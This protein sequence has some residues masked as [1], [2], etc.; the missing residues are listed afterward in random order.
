ML[1]TVL[2]FTVWAILHAFFMFS[3][4]HIT[5]TGHMSGCCDRHGA[6]IVG[7]C[8]LRML[9]S[10]RSL[11]EFSHSAIVILWAIYILGLQQND[12]ESHTLLYVIS[13]GYHIYDSYWNIRDVFVAESKNSRHVHPHDIPDPGKGKSSAL[14]LLQNLISAGLV[15]LGLRAVSNELT[16]WRSSVVPLLM[17]LHPSSSWNTPSYTQRKALAHHLLA[18]TS[19]ISSLISLNLLIHEL[20]NIFRS[21]LKLY[22]ISTYNNERMKESMWIHQDSGRNNTAVAASLGATAWRREHKTAQADRSAIEGFLSG[23]HR[24]SFIFIRV[25][26]GFLTLGSVLTT[27]ALVRDTAYV[28]VAIVYHGLAVYLLGGIVSSA[29]SAWTSSEDLRRS[30]SWQLGRNG[31]RN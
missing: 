21:T 29:S 15:G 8:R 6:K 27:E 19:E 16:N 11:L 9:Q 14:R 2:V 4:S 5:V 17:D 28:T 7:P 20:P 22:R 18:K 12:V 23:L 24:I 1:Q 26:G 3:L 25:L 13:F 31:G 30:L 10:V